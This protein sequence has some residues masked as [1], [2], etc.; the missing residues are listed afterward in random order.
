VERF[1][2][3]RRLIDRTP[4]GRRL[5]DRGIARADTPRGGMQQ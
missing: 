1:L 5:T 2:I 4:R 3:E